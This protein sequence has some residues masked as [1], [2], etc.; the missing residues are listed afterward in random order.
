MAGPIG[1]KCDQPV[2]GSLP[3]G[4]QLIEERADV[5]D[6]MD[7]RPL[8]AAPDVVGFSHTTMLN[9]QG[10]RVGVIVDKKPVANLCAVAINRQRLLRQAP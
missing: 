10:K 5:L 3:R 7:V 1:N 9:D 2:P 8:A 6:H 4:L